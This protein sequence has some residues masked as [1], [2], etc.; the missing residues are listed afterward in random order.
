MKLKLFAG[1]LGRCVATMLVLASSIAWAQEFPTKPIRLMVPYPAGGTTDLM[2]RTLQESMQKTL[3][4]SI[5]VINKGGAT[6]TIGT[7]EVAQAAPDGYSMLFV[8]G[9]Q[10]MVT[11]LVVKD[12]GYAPKDFV[13]IGR[14]SAAPLFAVING[15]LPVNDLKG[16]I[17][18]ARKQPDGVE[19]ASSG[20]GA[21][22]HLAT[23]ML[24]RTAGIKMLHVPF[25]GTAP[26]T[27]AVLSGQVKL[28]ITSGSTAMSS[29]IASGKLK[30]LGITSAE[31]S[32]L[33][34][35]APTLNTVV[36]GYAVDIWWGLFAPAATPPA[37]VAKLNEALKTALSLPEV[38]AGFEK[39]GVIAKASTVEELRTAMT[40]EAPRWAG[41]VREVGLKPE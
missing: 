35:G 37:I 13:P 23:E 32:A 31:P 8:I 17:E 27:Q 39:F 11:P 6:G 20:I 24:A 10:L 18:Y 30:L 25:A 12:A 19:Y 22:S 9:T 21:T 1:R 38:R 3:G 29:Y 36:P 34:P 16:F 33:A 7:R 5:I 14:V 41:V 15:A 4:Q 26:A 2:A 28:V 40:D